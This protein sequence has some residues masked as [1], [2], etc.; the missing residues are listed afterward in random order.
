MRTILRRCVLAA[1]SLLVPLSFSGAAESFDGSLKDFVRL[2]VEDGL[3][4]N[5]VYDVCIDRSGCIW[6]ATAVG[7]SRYDGMTVTNF[8]KEEMT[9]RSNYVNYVYCDSRGRVWV[10]TDN[11]VAIY[12]G[13]TGK[14]SNLEL[15]TGVSIESPTAWLFEDGAG[16]MWV[17]FNKNGLMAVDCETFAAR[18]YFYDFPWKDFPYFSRIWFD[19]ATGLYLLSGF[20]NGLY[21]ADLKKEQIVPFRDAETGEEPFAGRNI[22]GILRFDENT[23]YITCAD[24]TFLSIDP[25]SREGTRIAARF[26]DNVREVR[27]INR[28]SDTILGIATTHGVFFY[29]TETGELL[30]DKVLKNYPASLLSGEIIS[31]KVLTV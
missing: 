20:E 27:R 26:P 31:D 3:A 17:S 6:M 14:F 29:D 9:V 1:L 22:K 30:S 16:T 4:S 21:Y 25:Y 12:D 19:P 15:L 11:G 13:A 23:F 18:R 7:L 24:G 10:G 2:T 5:N 8:F 28:V